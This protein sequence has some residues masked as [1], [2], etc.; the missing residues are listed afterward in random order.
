[1][2]FWPVFDCSII[3]GPQGILRFIL[4]SADNNHLMKADKTAL[5]LVR[6]KN[7]SGIYYLFSRNI[8]TLFLIASLSFVHH[9]HDKIIYLKSSN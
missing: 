1:M 8:N 7:L 9:N 5:T 3:D 4:Y 2:G 6:I